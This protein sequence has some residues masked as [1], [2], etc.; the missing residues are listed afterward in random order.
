MV[1][2]LTSQH[3]QE[4]QSR[5]I[6]GIPLEDLTIEC[7]RLIQ[8]ALLSYRYLFVLGDELDRLRVALRVRGFRN[9]AS[10]H[11]YRTVGHAAGTLLVRGY[12]RADRVSAAMRCRGFDG[13]FRSLAVFRTRR[14]DVLAL[15][16]AAACATALVCL[17]V[18]VQ[19]T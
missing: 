16:L 11:S 6:G 5:K 10:W 13:R 7:F 14:A 17:D 18:C 1:A 3:S 12:E 4:L 15:A 9:R 8:L 2:L 19:G